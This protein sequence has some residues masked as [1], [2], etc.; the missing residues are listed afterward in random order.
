MNRRIDYEIDIRSETLTNERIHIG[1]PKSK[2][3]PRIINSRV[4][5]CE[6]IIQGV[7]K[8]IISKVV[9]E[10]CTIKCKRAKSNNF[11][12]VQFIDCKVYGS[13]EGSVLDSPDIESEGF[14]AKISNCDFTELNMN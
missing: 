3:A 6:V 9:F 11:K 8:S 14:E 10:N 5:D 1:H 12:L 2:E 4:E 13:L 7:S